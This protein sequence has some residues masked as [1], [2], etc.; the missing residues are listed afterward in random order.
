[1]SNIEEEIVSLVTSRICVDHACYFTGMC[2]NCANK[3]FAIVDELNNRGLLTQNVNH[4]TTLSTKADFAKAPI[5]TIVTHPFGAA[6]K[7]NDDE[8]TVTGDE[9]P[10][11]NDAMSWIA[12][13]SP[14][15]V[16]RWGEGHTKEKGD[17]E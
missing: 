3:G 13:E 2:E 12:L 5:G 9:N 8:W 16:M 10:R 11:R 1:M 4:P 7:D 17:N 15:V 14:Y 6:I